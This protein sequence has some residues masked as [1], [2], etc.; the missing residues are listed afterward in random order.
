MDTHN[1]VPRMKTSTG[2]I[3]WT[4]E[5]VGDIFSGCNNAIFKALRRCS[6]KT[7]W[8]IL[9][10]TE[11][12]MN[13]IKLQV[14]YK[15]RDALEAALKDAQAAIAYWRRAYFLMEI[16]RDKALEREAAL[17]VELD[18]YQRKFGILDEPGS[19]KFVRKIS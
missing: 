9:D 12:T 13:Q 5:T 17:R 2:Y 11:G 6:A 4:C 10:A 8:M 14:T 16:E 7:R 15:F 19:D 18:L 3:G 1:D